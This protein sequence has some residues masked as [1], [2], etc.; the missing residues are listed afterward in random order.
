MIQSPVV[1]RNGGA[2]TPTQNDADSRSDRETPETDRPIFAAKPKPKV[3]S[4]KY[5]MFDFYFL[6]DFC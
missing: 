5:L 1:M 6:R 2:S 3:R 4:M